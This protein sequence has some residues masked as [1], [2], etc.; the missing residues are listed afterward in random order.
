[1]SCPKI[2]VICCEVSFCVLSVLASLTLQL[3]FVCLCLIFLSLLNVCSRFK[4]F[5]ITRTF[6]FL[7]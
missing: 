5:V 6:L 1:M 3:A 4:C 7:I 2:I